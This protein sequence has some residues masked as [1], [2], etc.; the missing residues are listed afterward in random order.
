MDEI[1]LIEKQPPKSFEYYLQKTLLVVGERLAIILFILCIPV[2]FLL[3]KA[4]QAFSEKEKEVFVKQQNTW[5]KKTSAATPQENPYNMYSYSLATVTPSPTP[6][7]AP[8]SIPNLSTTSDI[9]DKLAVCESKGNWS[10]NTG[11]GYYGGLQFSES[12]WRGVGGTNMPHEASRDEQIMRGKMLQ[13]KR[14]WGPWGG[15]SKKLGLL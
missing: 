7:P 12:A 8:T 15:C 10:I 14:G 1:N 11:N 9:W 2:F 6:T 5:Y 13:E 4:P 3:F